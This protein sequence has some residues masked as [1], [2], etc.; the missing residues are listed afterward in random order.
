MRD[1]NQQSSNKFVDTLVEK[2][3]DLKNIYIIIKRRFWIIILFTIVTT[4]AGYFYTVYNN[5]P[6][7]ESST[8]IILN[9][10]QEMIKTLQ[11]IIEDPAVLEHVAAELKID[12]SAEGLAKQISV[13]NIGN[14][15]VVSIKV[16]D[17]NA[18]QAAKIANT[19]ASVF[20]SEI[21]NI[22]NFRG[23]KVLSKAEPNPA[24]IN[25]NQMK[26]ILAAFVVGILGGVG[27]AFLLNALENTIRTEQDVEQFLGLPVLGSVAKINKRNTRRKRI[28]PQILKI[29]GE[30]IDS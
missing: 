9:T 21:V 25:D 12:R 4:T 11:V 24:S 29:R 19:T 20:K 2:E 18:E 14:S 8:R 3:I 17:S 13:S 6:L 5:V 23:V 28:K 7:Y 10:D 27:L 16:V 1:N 22:M 26:M 15:Q 30:T